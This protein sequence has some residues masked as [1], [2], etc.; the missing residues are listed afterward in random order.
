MRHPAAL[1][2]ALTALCLLL[3]L[4]SRADAEVF[5]DVY[6]GYSFTSESDV[7]TDLDTV[8]LTLEDVEFDEAFV[9]GGRLGYWFKAL[10]F[11]GVALD[12]SYFQPDIGDQT[13][14]T[15]A[16]PSL[17]T[18]RLD[19]DVVSVG[20]QLLL[21]LPI[22]IVKPYVF[23]GPAVFVT[24]AEARNGTFGVESDRTGAEATLGL[25]AGAGIR[26]VFFG[27]LGVFAEYQFTRF[28]PEF[29]FE[30]GGARR[31]VET[32]IETHHGVVGATIQF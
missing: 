1:P 30:S 7:D 2:A 9:V 20:P 32:D 24:V 18:G 14:R 25:K 4:A 17:R 21:K 10:P 22:P 19:L 23:A 26:F 15:A 29:E 5:L 3:S 31:K 8:G 27:F 16:G 12:V 13:V 6:A 11:F 28:S